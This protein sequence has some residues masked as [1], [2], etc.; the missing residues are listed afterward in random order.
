MNKLIL[1]TIL[2]LS[3]LTSISAES[4]KLKSDSTGKVYGPFEHKN[5]A[6]ITIGKHKFILVKENKVTIQG[7]FRN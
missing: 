5:G 1:T 3:G 7:L 4:F 6:K 2:M